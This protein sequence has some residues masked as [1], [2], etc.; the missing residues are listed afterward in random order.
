[1]NHTLSG[2]TDQMQEQ[3]F[4]NI[5]NSEYLHFNFYTNINYLQIQ[6]LTQFLKIE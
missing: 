1:M 6:S 5:K 4:D 3:G 2:Q